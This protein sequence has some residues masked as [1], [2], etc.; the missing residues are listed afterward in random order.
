MGLYDLI[1]FNY[2]LYTITVIHFTCNFLRS[3]ASSTSCPFYTSNN[4][5]RF[6]NLPLCC[7]SHRTSIFD[8]VA[9]CSCSSS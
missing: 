4:E 8:S 1:T 9:N 6:N 7:G 5:L 2:P 3:V